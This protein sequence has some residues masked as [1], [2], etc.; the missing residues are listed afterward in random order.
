MGIASD[1]LC[2][3]LVA[4]HWSMTLLYIS[5]HIILAFLIVFCLF[6]LY[7]AHECNLS[8]RFS[9]IIMIVLSWICLFLQMFPPSTPILHFGRPAALWAYYSVVI[10]NCPLLSPGSATLFQVLCFLPSVLDF[11]WFCC[12][13]STSINFFTEGAWDEFWLNLCV[14]WLKMCYFSI[15]INRNFDQV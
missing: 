12:S 10:W 1:G 7:L 11:C 8:P 14:E 2:H 3:T 13:I 15:T 5:V 4:L 6:V 9:I